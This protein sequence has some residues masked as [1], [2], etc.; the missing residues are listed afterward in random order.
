MHART[1]ASNRLAKENRASRDLRVRGNG[2]SEENKG[3]PK[4][5]FFGTK[6]AKGSHKGKTS[7]TGLSGLENPKSEACS[8]TQESAQGCRTNTS[9]NDGWNCHEC[10]DG[11]SFEELNDDWSSVGG[12]EGW[13]Q[14]Y[15]TSASSFSTWSCGCQCHQQSEAV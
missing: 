3:N 13:E 6:G 14:T 11:W 7:T 1:Q 15:D 5:K 10:N 8:D 2:K 9:R 12:L 4:G